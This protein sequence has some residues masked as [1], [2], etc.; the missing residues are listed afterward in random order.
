MGRTRSCRMPAISDPADASDTGSGEKLVPREETPVDRSA[1][2]ERGTSRGLDHSDFSQSDARTAE[3]NDTRCGA[4]ICGILARCPDDPPAPQGRPNISLRSQTPSAGCRY[5]GRRAGRA[6]QSTPFPS[7][8]IKRA[9]PRPP[10]PLSRRRLPRRLRR[11]LGRSLSIRPSRRPRQRPWPGPVPMRHFRL[12]PTKAV[13]RQPCRPLGRIRRPSRRRAQRRAQP[14]PAAVTRF[15]SRR[16]VARRTL[17][18][19]SGHSKPNFPISWAATS[20][21]SAAPILAIRAFIIA[22]WSGPLPPWNRPRRCVRSLKAAGGS[23]IVQKELASR[24]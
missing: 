21:W 17:R 9:V 14:Q 23:C 11:C 18:P 3:R 10:Q 12:C 6:G 1:V 5:A 7:G 8:P 24:A 22:L 19:S 2:G 20:R 16:S 15:R 13:R 4:D